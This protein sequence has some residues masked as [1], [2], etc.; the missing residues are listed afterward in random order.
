MVHASAVYTDEQV[1]VFAADKRG[2]KTTLALRAVLDHGWRWLSNDHLILLPDGH[3]GLSVTS[4]P[5]PI[6]VKVGTLVDL[7]DRL[8]VPWDANGFDVERWRA[9]PP[10][11]RHTADNAA[12][13]T[14]ARFRQPN[15]VVVPLAGHRVSVVFP[16]YAGPDE[17]VTGP[18]PVDVRETAVVLAGH[19]R[20][21]WISD[22]R[23]HQRHLSFAHR[24]IGVFA[25][26]G[27]RLVARLAERAGGGWR[28]VHCGHPGPLLDAL[29]AP[30]AAR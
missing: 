2:G 23:L 4:L 1:V 22:D 19:V 7:W 3:G 28:W 11:L 30:G 27:A 26:D 6:P 18:E 15:P 16:H 17:A 12:Y 21:D 25:A 5:T 14:F 8:P 13:F 29:A 10:P 20:T 24:D 9:V